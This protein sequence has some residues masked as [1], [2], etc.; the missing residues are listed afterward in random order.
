[1]QRYARKKR[2]TRL[3]ASILRTRRLSRV[4]FLF[5]VL[6]AVVSLFSIS[7]SYVPER[8]SRLVPRAIKE[9]RRGLVNWGSLLRLAQKEKKYDLGS[10]DVCVHVLSLERAS[11]RREETIRSLQAQG[12]CLELFQAVDGLETLENEAVKKYAGFKKQKRL[13]LTA[14]WSQARVGKLYS[15]YKA[16]VLYSDMMKMALH[17]RLR[18][19]VYMSH[20][21]LWQR[22][23]DNELPFLVILE[24][25]VIIEK[26][27]VLSL[28]KLLRQLPE[29]WGLLYLNGS[30]KIFGEKFSDGLFQSR[31]GVGMFGYAISRKAATFFLTK[32]ALRSNRAVDLMMDNEVISG[33]ILAFH[34][35]P[36]LVHIIQGLNSTLAY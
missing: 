13:A 28:L 4:L 1:M 17:E 20:I 6:I 25:D 23:I 35:F 15:E 31:G 18:F 14:H 27:F 7:R 29:S 32:P 8:L 33:R 3:T 11:W 2:Y 16:N 9:V 10:G 26:D 12:V 22:M 36:P 21:T 24:D 19:G 5:T 30:K 34:A